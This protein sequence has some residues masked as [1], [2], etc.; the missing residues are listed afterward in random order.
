MIGLMGF[1]AAQKLPGSV[2][3]LDGVV[4]AYAGD[5]MAPF[6]GDFNLGTLLNP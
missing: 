2:P 5:V 1:M 3:V 6:E 4:K